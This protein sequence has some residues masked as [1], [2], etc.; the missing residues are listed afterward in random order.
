MSV[1]IIGGC[2]K[3][4]KEPQ[5][6]VEK[7]D[8]KSLA[9]MQP[10]DVIVAINDNHYLTKS[11]YEEMLVKI[12]R[13]FRLN[14]PNA[15]PG[16]VTMYLRNKEKTIVAEYINRCLL[17]E[18]AR[19]RGINIPEEELRESIS[20][21]VKNLSA[22]GKTLEQ[23]LVHMGEDRE[24]FES[25]TQE[26]MLISALLNQEFGEDRS[27]V[28]AEQIE[29]QRE[30][31]VK[32][33]ERCV[34]TNQLVMARGQKLVEQIKAGADFET[35]A[36]ANSEEENFTT[37]YWGE[38][39]GGE[40]EDEQVRA[41]ALNEPIGSVAGPFDTEDGLIIIKILK[42]VKQ[43][44]V[45]GAEDETTVHLGRIFLRLGQSFECP[46]DKELRAEV[47][48]ER[49]ESQMLPFLG[50]LRA[51]A[52]VRFPHGTNLWPVVSKPKSKQSNLMSVLN[53]VE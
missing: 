29:A 32:Y 36:I 17:L 42:R 39:S 51:D 9:E 28:T 22:Q 13:R 20:N 27:V 35:V 31:Y 10:A 24:Q 46:D 48:R 2:S 7:E 21:A 15:A 49:Q 41:A 11:A 16:M 45:E 50:K 38:F 37:S 1:I 44:A 52:N 12:D 40:I 4:D 5:N 53:E 30:S 34:A 47:L 18:E 14:R 6:S 3:E 25:M 26:R 33:N 23:V 43:G 8:T 19:K